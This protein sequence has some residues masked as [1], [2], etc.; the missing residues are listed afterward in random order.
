MRE[1]KILTNTTPSANYIEIEER[2]QK[3]LQ[4][5]KNDKNLPALLDKVRKGNIAAVQEVLE[6]SQSIIYKVM[7]TI[8]DSR[9]P[10][11]QRVKAASYALERLALKEVDSHGLEQFL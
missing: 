5:E 11:D 7:L 1:I 10:N 8:P 2:M 3:C 9:C 6:A 4:V